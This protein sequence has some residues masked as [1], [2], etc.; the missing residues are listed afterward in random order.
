M[1]KKLRIVIL[2]LIL[3]KVAQSSWLAQGA[4]EWKTG[5]Y[6]ALYPV[7]VN[8][9][10]EVSAYLRSLNKDD[11]EPLA[12]YYAKEAAHYQLGIHRPIQLQW[13]EEVRSIP[14]A[15]PVDQNIF[16]SVL[17]SL[18]FRYFAWRNSPKVAVPPDIRLYLLYYDPLT[19]PQL[20]HSSALNKGRIGRV[21]LFGHRSYSKQNMVIIAHELLHTLNASDKYDLASNQPLF[22]HGYAEPDRQPRY[23]QPF[24]ELMGGRVPVSESAAAI[25]ESL[26][27]T[28]IGEK[29]AR[30][31]GWLRTPAT[32]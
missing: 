28:L 21:N 13:G 27:H 19:H 16:S 11:F 9:S 17:W 30:E 32:P 7:N 20:S 3:A 5:L 2:L 29:T 25:P 15:P 23:P 18:Q 22:P 6:V 24:A 10:P 31:I 1:W 8:G 14:P 4:L 12:Q 26:D